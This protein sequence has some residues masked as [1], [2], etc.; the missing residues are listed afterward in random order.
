MRSLLSP[1][2]ARGIYEAPALARFREVHFE[3]QVDRESQRTKA[4]VQAL[5]FN[6]LT[7]EA[8]ALLQ[9]HKNKTLFILGSGASVNKLTEKNF[10]AVKAG[11]SIGMNAWVSHGFVPDAYSFEADSIL[12]P[13]S[14]EIETMSAA[15][16]RR[17]LS[18]P[19]TL[20]LLFRPKTPELV[21]RMVKV[22]ESLRPQA[23]MY[24]RHN[25]LTQTNSALRKDLGPL[26]V[27]RLKN[28][29]T[30]PV[31]IDNGASVVRMIELG[32]FAGFTEIVLLGIDLNSSS[33]FWEAL[34]AP[35]EYHGM[36]GCYQR[37]QN[38]E[39]DT[40]ETFD[41][42]YSSLLFIEELANAAQRY[43]DAGVYIG[44]EGSALSRTIQD[45]DWKITSATEEP[46]TSK[47]EEHTCHS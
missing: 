40:L 30:K 42:P 6:L 41:R 16:A 22:P 2:L 29:D 12:A 39:H 4:V 20:L 31:L 34:D 24:G 38:V 15:L 17:A 45:Y 46:I 9:G 43:F 1:S 37:P 10:D 8:L 3:R 32:L 18:N 28:F 47:E 7:K 14:L 35:P 19:D 23:F 25:L 26:L 11:Y 21:H 13:P 27:N 44:T 36:R 33:Y 5:G